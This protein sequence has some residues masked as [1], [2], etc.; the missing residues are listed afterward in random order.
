MKQSKV[1]A[2][3]L[4]FLTKLDE[5]EIE[6]TLMHNRPEAIA[7]LIATPGDRWEIE[8][9]EDGSIEVERFSS[10]GELRGEEA[11]ADV[12]ALMA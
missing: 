8:F 11:I 3:L 2:C 6:Y 4:G 9:L 5:N 7:I 1:Y 10:T 12:L